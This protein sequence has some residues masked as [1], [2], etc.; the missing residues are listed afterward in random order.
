MKNPQKL[1][2]YV[3]TFSNYVSPTTQKKEKVSDTAGGKWID[4]WKKNLLN[5]NYVGKIKFDKVPGIDDLSAEGS[6]NVSID[7][8]DPTKV[9][10]SMVN[11]LR[12]L[13]KERVDDT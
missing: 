9:E 8:R 3:N 2:E 6:E 12:Q 11:H 5:Q 10:T 1:V 13:Y 4:W 7:I